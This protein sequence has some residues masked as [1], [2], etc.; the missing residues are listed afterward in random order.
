MKTIGL[1]GGMSWESTVTYYQLINSEIGERLGGLHSAKCLLYSVDFAEIEDYQR[2]GEWDRA[3][4]TLADAAV[5]LE[6]AG[7]DFIVL[8]TNTMHKVIDR[9]EAAIQIPVLH[10]GDVTARA[11]QQKHLDKVGLVGTAYTMEED[12]LIERIR[13]HGIEV[14]VPDETEREI[15]NKVIFEELCLGRIRDTS[16]TYFLEVV[17]RLANAGA[18]GVILGCTEVGLLI[19]QDDK[20]APFFDT[21]KLH[22]MAAVD[23]ALE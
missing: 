12:F 8:C 10:I 3:G 18:A 13:A 16:R 15:I 1:I 17:D 22:A 9:L 6:S 20:E 7:A 11:I 2:Q 21:T 4:E 5:R 14:M 19:N 23:M